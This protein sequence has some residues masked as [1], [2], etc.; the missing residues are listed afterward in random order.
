M[1]SLAEIVDRCPDL[2]VEVGGHTD[3]DGAASN[4][5]RLSEARARS[6]VQFLSRAGVGADRLEAVGYGEAQPIA[7]NATADGKAK[8]RRIAFTVLTN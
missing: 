3:S 4:N 5:L 2:R 7:S 1:N 6:V 8:N